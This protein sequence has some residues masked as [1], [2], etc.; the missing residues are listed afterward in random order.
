[1]AVR[2]PLSR[3]RRQ[4][5]SS[6]RRGGSHRLSGQ[7]EQLILEAL[8]Q[9]RV[10]D[11]VPTV[12][13]ANDPPTS[14]QDTSFVR[15][16]TD[17]LIG[18][19]NAFTLRFANASAIDTGYGPYVDLF[20]PV[21][22]ADGLGDGTTPGE[23]HDGIGFVSASYLGQTLTSHVIT[24]TDD[25]AGVPHP[26]AKDA[27][28][29]PRMLRPADFPGFQ[30]GD[31]V[32]VLE[33][34]LGSVTPGQPPVDIVVTTTVDQKADVNVPLDVVAQAG[35][36]FGGDPV[37]N[38]TGDP[39]LLGASSTQAFTPKLY[40]ITKE[41]LAHEYE[42]AT[43]PNFTQQ[44]R[45]RVD[46]ADGQT[47][48]DLTFSDTLPDNLQFVAVTSL[49]GGTEVVGSAIDPSTTVP[50]G[51]LERVL[52]SVTGTTSTSDAV[53]DF[54]YFVPT[55]DAAG[56][57]VLDPVS[58]NDVTIPNE[59]TVSGSWT[60]LDSRDPATTISETVQTTGPEG[61][62]DPDT[63]HPLTAKSLATQK[64]VSVP[65]GGTVPGAVLTYTINFQI[66][67]AF[68][69][70]NLVITDPLGDG[71]VLSGTPTLT[72]HD[73]HVGTSPA[74]AFDSANFDLTADLDPATGK[75]QL[76]F[77]VSDEL[78][79]RSFSNGQLVGG[80]IP[81]GGT[82]GTPLASQPALFTPGTTGSIV[83][84]AVVQDTYTGNVPSGEE[85]LGPGDIVDNSVTIAGDLVS[86]AD[87]TTPTGQSEEDTSHA[88]SRVPT[89]TFAKTVYAFNGSTAGQ[90][91]PTTTLVTAGDTLTYR[92]RYTLPTSDFENLLLT[93]YLPLPL[94]D[95]TDAGTD[96]T[97][98]DAATSGTG[99]APAAGTWTY[100]PDDTF[101]TIAAA[102][103]P[104]V[105]T[106]AAANSV[107]FDYGTYDTPTNQPSVIDLLFTV[108]ASN[109]PYADNLKLA[110][111]AVITANNTALVPENNEGIAEI[112]SSEPELVITKGIVATDN[113]AGVF[114]PATVGPVS[115]TAPGTLGSR[116]TGTIS[117]SGLAATPIDSNLSEIDHADLVTYVIVVENQ[118]SGKFGAFDTIIKDSPAAGMAIPGLG[119]DGI[120][121]RVTDGA[122]NALPYNRV[123]TG[124]FDPNGALE[125]VDP[126]TT[127]GAIARG[128]DSSGSVVNDGSNIVVISYDMQVLQ[129]TVLAKLTNT[130]AV[131][132]YAATEG[133]PDFTGAGSL[134]D[135]AVITIATNNL[136][137][138]QLVSTEIVDAFN[139][140]NE[141]VIGELVT[142]RVTL[143]V[144]EATMPNARIVDSLDGRNR[145]AFVEMVGVTTSPGISITGSTTPVVSDS[146]RRLTFDLGDIANN[147]T[148]N[149]VAETITFEYRAVVLNVQAA[150]GGGRVRNTA[151]LT[152]DGLGNPRVARAANVTVIEPNVTVD[153]AAAFDA[154]GTVG[155]AGDPLT[156]TIQLSNTPRSQSTT[157]DAFEVA[158]EDAL[159]VG[160]GGGSLVVAPTFSVADPVGGLTPADFELVGSDAA[161]WTL[162]SKAPFDMPVDAARAITITI[163]GA[164]PAATTG[165]V[166][167]GDLITNG[168]SASWT[169]L[170][171]LV[172]VPR[173]TYNAT[174]VERTGAGGINDYTSTDTANLQ[175][176]GVGV[177]KTITS[178]SEN[179]TTNADRVVVGEVVRY[180]LE[181]LIPESTVTSFVLADALPAGL[182]YLDDGTAMVAFVS[183]GGGITSSTIP[184]GSGLDVSGSGPTGVTPTFAI[185]AAAID[186]GPTFT[187]GTDVSF[188]LG[189]VVNQDND[190]DDEYA[191]FEFNAVVTNV[192]S[193]QEN[194]TLTNRVA[195]LQDGVSSGSQSVNVQVAEPLLQTFGKQAVETDDV[196]P[197]AGPFDAGDVVRYL[198]D[199][200]AATG[201]DRSVAYD[202]IV[203][204][205]LPATELFVPGSLR[206][207][208]NGSVI[209]S[210]FSVSV[211]GQQLEV[212][213]DEIQPGD[214]LRILY[215]VSLTQA[216]VAG[217]TVTNTADLT[218]TSLPGG[219]STTNPTG[220]VTPGASGTSNGERNG[221]G[222][223]NDY[224][225]QTDTTITIR[226]PDLA[227]SIFEA[228]PVETT[229]NRFDPNR[230]DF[231]I[232]EVVTFRLTATLPEGTTEGLVLSDQLPTGMEFLEDIAGNLMAPP[233]VVAVGGNIAGSSLAVG[234]LGTLDLA[235]G[236]VTFDFG[237]VVN[238]PDGIVSDAD[239]VVV[240]L[241][242]QV[243]NI[244]A[245][246]AGGTLTNTGSLAYLVGGSTLTTSNTVTA[247]LVEPTLETTKDIVAVELAG[248]GTVTPVG[249]TGTAAL[250]RGDVVTYRV[251]VQHAGNSSGPAF[252]VRVA[253][254]LPAG[255]TL[256][257]GSLQV[258]QDV[259][260]ASS[261][262]YDATIVTENT[263]GNAIE[264]VFDYIDV[265]GNAYANPGDGN[266]AVIEYR[267]IVDA[268][269]PVGTLTNTADVTYDSLYTQ[270][271]STDFPSTTRAY[272]TD[273]V[274]HVVIDVNSI[275]G[276][277]YV[278]AN[279]NGVFDTGEQPLA[280]VT[281]RLT[282]TR[283]AGGN[284]GPVNLV[285][286]ADGSYLFD[287]LDPGTY[288]VSQPTQPAG[289]DDGRDTVGTTQP[290]PDFGGTI[291]GSG[292]G[293][294]TDTITTIVIPS[295]A[296]VAN[297]YDFGELEVD[298]S[299]AKDDGQTTYVPG[300]TV[301][302]TIVVTNNGVGDVTGAVVTD[303]LPAGTSFLS[304]TNGATYD[305]TSDMVTFLPGTLAANGG[306]DSFQLT[307]AA[308]STRTGDLVNTTVV[309]PPPGTTDLTPGNNTATDIDTATPRVD[310]SITKDDGQTKYSPGQ[311]LTYTIVVTN[312]GPSF[313]YAAAVR[314]TIPA[315]I[316][317]VTWTATY[318]GSGS[319]GTNI[320]S[321]NTLDEL[322]DLAV[323]GT[324]TYQI[325]GTVD[326]SSTG[327]LVNTATVTAPPGFVD[328]T[329]ANNIA[330]DI[331]EVEPRV[332]LAVTKTD[333]R[334]T[335]Q[336][337]A[338]TTYTVI[339]TNDGPGT[340][341]GAHVVDTL[342]PEMPSATWTATFSPGSTGLT[343]GSSVGT[344]G[345]DAY[346]TLLP[347][348]SVT[349]TLS[350]T[351]DP[352]AVSLMTNS[353]SVTVAPGGIDTDPTNNTATDTDYRPLLAVGTDVDCEST[354]TVTVLD[355]AT[356]DVVSQFE[357]YEP[358]FR[359]GVRTALTDVDGD[360]SPEVVTAPGLGRV[361]EIR[362]F[363]IDGSELPQYRMTPYGTGFYGGISIA[364][365]D[366][367]G[368]GVDEL[369][370]GQSRGS[371]QVQVYRG[372]AGTPG[373]ETT[374]FVSF[375]PYGPSHLNGVSVAGADV[376]TFANGQTVD[377]TT[378]DHRHEVAVAS[379]PGASQPARVFDLSATPRVVR[380]IA[381]DPTT[382]LGGTTISAG[383]YDEDSI[384][385]LILAG[386][387]GDGSVTAIYS[388]RTDTAST[389]PLHRYAA[390]ADLGSLHSPTGTTGVDL[391]GDGRIDQLFSVQGEAGTGG[392]RLYDTAGALSN[393]LSVLR[394]PLSLASQTSGPEPS[395]TYGPNQ[396]PLVTTASGLQYR[397]L[398]VGSGAVATAGQ[399]VTVHYVG[400]RQNGEVFDSSRSRGTPF[401]FTLGVGQVI[402]GWDEGVAGMQVGGR[403]TLIIPADLAY[404]NTPPGTV[405]QPGDTLVF[406]V[407]LLSAT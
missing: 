391:S 224:A 369:I 172:A 305:S 282:G 268:A 97:G 292:T 262:F 372:I 208:R 249:P 59:A 250:N 114:S 199:V 309:T 79:T 289:Y 271:S 304:A 104:T 219:G 402:D 103:T 35:F 237:T 378:A 350:G 52:A 30:A 153:K 269:A 366:V 400:S 173:S 328:P 264:V 49:T 238:S 197:A 132:Q 313:A 156:Y 401:T 74:A 318:T 291:P 90:P 161:G 7:R 58:G 360:G 343:S 20:L 241:Q 43:G 4:V 270:R 126:S 105:S 316:S 55:V 231:T 393:S 226:S 376:G 127:Q 325:T 56:S 12:V 36:R 24:L 45:L 115:F 288:T 339:V 164:L 39:P 135:P 93:D 73:G 214:D 340:A 215:D 42:T 263:G 72:V 196:T 255:L 190:A 108:T 327:D 120:N 8:E 359:G 377:A 227:K 204:D 342:P 68:A 150:Q 374:P 145:L 203:S 118:G 363:E 41:N 3:R 82:G 245:L 251:T 128:I 333:G 320:G 382:S 46:I 2:F 346:V 385:D 233:R 220:S 29:N 299:I 395:A 239:Q 344:A 157:A 273:A 302:Y 336:A 298:L 293:I 162:R 11:A 341:V 225:G 213:I 236:R 198:I 397:D 306:S 175:V 160:V 183:N 131:T 284:V 64:H 403:R 356:G 152:F 151:R 384:D 159:P 337:G 34:P 69:F 207:L 261:S 265:P 185:P 303:Q 276:H 16:E 181:A 396:V 188:N 18:E 243:Q 398:A 367:D 178:T 294:G 257:P 310:L 75:D 31:Q 352:D 380:E 247:D 65:A 119:V 61:V 211:V 383:R 357:A 38:P 260:Y 354:P 192:A 399:S 67:D 184:A 26:F 319:G 51:L 28:G 394:A 345:I 191:I 107:V 87:L 112:T 324:V 85:F 223:I 80:L 321:G 134:T 113:P 13:F 286:A 277:V 323:G 368:D 361:G 332:D 27:S 287:N 99:N 170:P 47:V 147:D 347:G 78:V 364:T 407:E 62:W 139:A 169:S 125:L 5:L 335:Y 50:G 311:S 355:P 193:N 246:V 83:F 158:F 111:R 25:P 362:V 14:A 1:M 210:G 390:F 37:D 6:S 252:T 317:G 358:G 98:F 206:V 253:D 387:Y 95:V 216:V 21:T 388:G 116:F 234:S 15:L 267:A 63:E 285:T 166:T 189:T 57:Q 404:G 141:A 228:S 235:N 381:G 201:N 110:N 300:Q 10:L 100:G 19:Q 142:Y 392:T 154:G 117:S 254:T 248:G 149:S 146:G 338:T 44:F 406:D 307:L 17:P 121:L 138:K 200:V 295:G 86:V 242:T 32:V 389:T 405:I 315:V 312:A 182:Q 136:L 186:G 280:G 174:A 259:V 230:P 240:E 140:N 40:R 371:G 60:P 353:V 109:D 137:H 155:D 91:L 168:A 9:R 124:L 176:R 96:I 281:M 209:G 217:S 22:G 331:D 290:A 256:V 84:Q 143:T 322:V 278:D 165:L 171:G 101:H 148:D 202:A 221:S 129:N 218:Y 375:D 122:G 370:T 297:D 348:G 133:G 23:E 195:F 76:V 194:T 92:L 314:D 66:S 308:A 386:G 123:G 365:D 296:A 326:P 212:T 94:F 33:L 329:P 334:E 275:A 232:G 205:T 349:Y 351:V 258:V 301:T 54:S 89:T 187:D 179:A 379:G 167:P 330:T 180:R 266:V 81:S 177:A 163:Q 244:P 279:N 222:G 106:D 102:P 130:G 71:Q 274:A 373:W 70:D 229:S 272:A 77:R 48:T 144:P 53:L 283:L 88:W